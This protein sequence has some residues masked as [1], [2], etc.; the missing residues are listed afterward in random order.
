VV[1]DNV[2]VVVRSGVECALAAVGG[3]DGDVFAYV[4]VVVAAAAAA[5]AG[6]D[7]VGDV[8]V[9]RNTVNVVF[10]LFLIVVDADVRFK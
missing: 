1:V 8:G 4:I 6:N 2:A 10:T 7:E 5:A 3:K 9:G